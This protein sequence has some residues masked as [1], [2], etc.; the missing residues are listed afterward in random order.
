MI[1]LVELAERLVA[2]PSRPSRRREFSHHTLTR[3]WWAARALGV[4]RLSV[5]LRLLGLLLPEPSRW[6]VRRA[7]DS[8]DPLGA[9]PPELGAD[10]PGR[11]Q[12]KSTL[13]CRPWESLLGMG[14]G[15]DEQCG[16]D[17]EVRLCS[18]APS[19]GMPAAQGPS[20]VVRSTK[21]SGRPVG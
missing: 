3:R 12:L 18:A 5:T 21:N 10:R 19:G 13:R 11:T 9:E 1:S 16:W 20:S 15:P 2:G 8:T 6:R 7:R 14:N 4:L 17:V